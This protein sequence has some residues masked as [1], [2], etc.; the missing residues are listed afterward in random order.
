MSQTL[1]DECL[2]HLER[3][4]S[5]QQFNTWIRPLHA[6]SDEQGLRLLAPNRFVKDWI[7]ERFLAR[8]GEILGEIGQPVDNLRVEIGTRFNET[9]NTP[10]PKTANSANTPSRNSSLNPNYT[11]DT[12]VEGK[13][14]QLARA[15]SSQIAMN[16]GGA[17]NP[18]F[19]YGGVGLG[20]TH[21]VHAVGNAIASSRSRSVVLK[22][23]RCARSGFGIKFRM[24]ASTWGRSSSFPLSGV[25]EPSSTQTR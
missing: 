12:F 14:N 21:L 2:S 24:R 18:L 8:I 25:A 16:P 15:A 4:L 7:D 17:Y 3:E 6:V 9:S 19:I 10:R 1:W 13:S 22:G 20:K 23:I 5:P 11:F